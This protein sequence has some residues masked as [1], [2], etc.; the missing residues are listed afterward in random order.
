MTLLIIA[1]E[2]RNENTFSFR[3]S[4]AISSAMTALI[5]LP[6]AAEARVVAADL[7]VV[8]DGGLLRSLALLAGSHGGSIAALQGSELLRLVGRA[9]IDELL[10]RLG[11]DRLYDR[12]NLED[13]REICGAHVVH[14]ADEEIEGFALVLDE[15]VA[16]AVAA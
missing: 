16:L 6:A 9:L 14:Q 7:V 10:L 1:S 3:P 12:G 2:E 8:V 13:G 5:L 11:L 4:D 15:R